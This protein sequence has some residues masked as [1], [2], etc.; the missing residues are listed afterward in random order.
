MGQ[1]ISPLK[2]PRLTEDHPPEDVND[3][4]SKAA[5]ELHLEQVAG[6]SSTGVNGRAGA[7]SPVF[8]I[9]G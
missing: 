3:G 4:D 5:D 2:T 8:V 6:G 7:G 9:S 1:A